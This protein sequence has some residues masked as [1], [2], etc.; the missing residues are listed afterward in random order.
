MATAQS[1]DARFTV[2][3]YTTAEAARYLDVRDTTLRRWVKGYHQ[4]YRDRP[5]VRGEPL[6]TDL[7][8]EKRGGPSIP[9]IGLA[10][11][12]FLSALRKAR[13]PL[14]QIRPA[15]EL[16][17]DKIG[18]EHALASRKLYLAGAQLLWEVSARGEIDDEARHGARDLIVLKDGQYVFRQVI[19]QYLQQIT[20]DEDYA[21]S[22]LLPGYEV[23][24]IAADLRTNFGKPYFTAT[25]TP[26]YVVQ[27]MLRARET[28]EDVAGDFGLPVDQV[29]EVAQRDGLLAA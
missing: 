21:R 16:V 5:P 13:M 23:A 29:T 2:P 22:V 1:D 4:E 3:L 28:I 6:I 8:P 19:E 11:G 9:F 18:V 15:L 24:R 7:P 14:Q 12:M 17:R 26:L 25:G 20:Y 27:N 10:E